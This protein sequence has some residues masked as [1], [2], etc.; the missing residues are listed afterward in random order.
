LFVLAA[1]LLLLGATLRQ[2]ASANHDERGGHIDQVSIDMG[3]PGVAVDVAGN[4]KPAVGDR[5]GNSVPDAE[6]ARDLVN[7]VV[8][9]CGNNIDD[10]QGDW[11]G[12]TVIA[13]TPVSFSEID[14]VA[15]DG[16]QVTLTPLE[17]CAEIIDDDVL[18]ADEDF[19]VAGQ[20]RL[21]IDITVGAQPGPGG[22]IPA[23]RLLQ[24]WKMFFR[25]DADVID[26]DLFNRNFLLLA[27]GGGSP[28]GGDGGD[29]ADLPETTSPLFATGFDNGPKEA[30]PGILA[31]LTIEGNA[32][33]M[34]NLVISPSIDDAANIF[35]TIDTILSARVAVSKDVDG[36]T[37]I[38][39][40]GREV[41]RC[42]APAAVG[43]VL[44]K[45]R[46]RRAC[47]TGAP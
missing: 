37:V 11:D 15:D 21:S 25:W 22:G 16:C 41:F 24:N 30:G 36:D 13:N 39:G 17:Q 2:D 5:D 12:D 6:G 31:R 20:D 40:P 34:A 3:P 32:A 29:V 7:G 10:D 35:I 23:D 26:V 27:S 18:N 43:H 19:L 33:G 42:C 47:I 28:F 14:N 8:G 9:T 1:A 38:S 46:N 44:A 45:S 4:G